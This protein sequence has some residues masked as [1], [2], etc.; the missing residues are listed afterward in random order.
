MGVGKSSGTKARPASTAQ[1][2]PSAGHRFD[3]GHVP[4][5]I[6][7]MLA[8]LDV[9]PGGDYL[10]A[11]FGAGGYTRAILEAGA[12][13]VFAIDRD[14]AAVS[15]ARQLAADWPALIVLEGRFGAMAELLASH[16][17]H[18]LDGIVLDLGV[19][20]MQLG[21]PSRGFSFA[22]DGPLDMRM[23]S[24]GDSAAAVI[25]RADAQT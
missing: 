5:M 11:T 16:G 3:H 18:R 7:E 17:V 9:R 22:A 4:V 15:R 10:D 1:A 19:S 2:A 24:H 14:P 20:S 13:R 8:A 21:D 23:S 12:A 25:N 6:D